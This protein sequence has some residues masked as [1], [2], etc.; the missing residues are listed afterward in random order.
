MFS[1]E[2]NKGVKASQAEDYKLRKEGITALQ[3]SDSCFWSK[4]YVIIGLTL[5]FA[6]LD[7]SVLYNLFDRILDQSSHLG[8]LMAFG[9]AILINAIALPTA[10]FIRQTGYGIKRAKIWAGLCIATFLLL[11]LGISSLRMANADMYEQSSVMSSLRNNLSSGEEVPEVDEKTKMK[12]YCTAG[13]MCIE[14]LATT[15][16][17]FFLSYFHDDELRKKIEQEEIRKIEMEEAIAD[18]K[19]S[20]SS[21]EANEVMLLEEDECAR[22]SA[23]QELRARANKL[24]SISRKLLAEH[25]QSAAASSELNHQLIKELEQGDKNKIMTEREQK[26]KDEHVIADFTLAEKTAV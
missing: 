20:I 18:L 15:L 2:K 19:A 3:N 22:E 26:E 25:L 7:T 17:I 21:M 5:G 16:V 14:P 9:I 10:K 8:I 12:A 13:F 23:V 4:S 24:K 11:F 6:L 1:K